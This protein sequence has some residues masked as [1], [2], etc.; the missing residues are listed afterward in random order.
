MEDL[1][2]LTVM[3][4]LQEQ[5]VS[6]IIVEYSG[7][8]DSGDIDY[9]EFTDINDYRVNDIDDKIAS[10][11]SDYIEPQLHKFSDWWNNDGGG[12]VLII[13][14]PS[15][16]WKADH[17]INIVSQEEEVYDGKITLT[18]KS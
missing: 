13:K 15:G 12:G 7:S 16:E 17:Y 3:L 9:I 10:Y 11:V 5:N 18:D 4:K 8:G 14:V 6:K 2:W 1:N